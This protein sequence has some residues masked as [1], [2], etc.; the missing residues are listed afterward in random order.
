MPDVSPVIL[1]GGSG[2]RLWPKSRATKP[3]P[4]LPL[5]DNETLFEATIARCAGGAFSS[6]TVVTG[7]AHLAHVRTQAAGGDL[8]IIVEPAARNTAPA[9]ALAAARMRADQT[10]LVC[11]SDHHIADL[12]AFTD[13]TNA[14]AELAQ[15]GWLVSFGIEAA[16]PEI[17]FGY[18]RKGGRICGSAY[19][20]A[21]FVEKP[22]QDLAEQY[23]A[24]GNYF[25]NGGIFCFTAGRYL[26]ELELAR[27]A[28]AEAVKRAVAEGREEAECFYPDAETFASVVGDSIDYAVMEQAGR[29]AVVPVSM[30]WSDIGNWPALQEARV[31]D[32]DGNT[33][34][35][36]A[37]LVD[38]R[39]VMVE[40]DGPRVSMIGLKD[41][42]VVVDGDEILITSQ[43][44]AQR[45][46]QLSGAKNQ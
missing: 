45:V 29:A 6:P 32:A 16:T 9:I 22:S 2:T 19:Q 25:W 30:G 27:P 33:V 28:M 44:G 10:M 38:C 13:A 7:V 15:K 5:I 37:E 23:V 24:D 11:P 40:S 35:G 3:K 18:I 36:R 34:L 8:S 4:F 12:G 31:T 43:S 1:C 21:Q 39:N 41:V 46:G 14:A 42:V 20:I 17:G 26:E